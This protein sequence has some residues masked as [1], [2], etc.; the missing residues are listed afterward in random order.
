MY[1]APGKPLTSQQQKVLAFVSQFLEQQGFPPTLREIGDAIGLVN[2][3]GVRGHLSALEKK[4]YI[5][6]AREKARSI[7]IVHPASALSRVKRKLHEVWGTDEGV[8]HHVVY[9]I[10][11]AT[12]LRAPC[13]TGLRAKLMEEAIESEAVEHGWTVL[14]KRVEPDHVVVIVQAWHNHS[15]QRTVHRFQAAGSAA[16]RRHPHEFPSGPL[17]GTGYV[18]TTDLEV[19]G[20]LVTKLLDSQ[21]KQENDHEGT[22]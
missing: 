22:S 17:W 14:E 15:A 6:R 11:W 1:T 10:A 3:N 13:L 20:E 5:T 21:G 2:V 16:R 12:H 7:Q 4:G 18:A 8:F 9:G 19:L